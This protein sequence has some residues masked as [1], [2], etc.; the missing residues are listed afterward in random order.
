MR[1]NR[2]ALWTGAARSR[3][4]IAR[5]LGWIG[6]WFCVGLTG[7]ISDELVKGIIAENIAL[8]ASSV[9]QSVV[10]GFLSGIAG[11]LTG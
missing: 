2:R 1:K 11:G 3:P 9:V 6:P 7:C 8:A 4:A 5:A 10:D